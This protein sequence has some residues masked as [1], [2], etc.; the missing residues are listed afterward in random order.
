M[1]NPAGSMVAFLFLVV[2]ILA[3]IALL[4]DKKRKRDEEKAAEN[5]PEYL[6]DSDYRQFPE[7][8]G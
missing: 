6:K 7:G 5:A 1:N 8:A 3:A 2:V 4:I